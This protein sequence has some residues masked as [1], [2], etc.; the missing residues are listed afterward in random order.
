M[1]LSLAHRDAHCKQD[2]GATEMEN[3]SSTCT[4]PPTFQICEPPEYC[5]PGDLL[6]LQCLWELCVCNLCHFPQFEIV[7][8]K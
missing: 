5:V 8:R 2:L 4:R 6:L 7:L 3:Q 1:R